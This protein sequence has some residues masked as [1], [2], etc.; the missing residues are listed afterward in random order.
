MNIEASQVRQEGNSLIFRTVPVVGILAL[1]SFTDDSASS[2]MAAAFVKK[3]RYTTNGVTYSN[4]FDLTAPNMLQIQ[5]DPEGIFVAEI[6]YFK[7]E[8]AGANYLT[9]TEA[10]FG[11]NQATV[12]ES[13]NFYFNNSLFKKYFNSTDPDVLN[14]YINVLEKLYEKGLVANFIERKDI[15]GSVEDF[16]SFFG[17]VARFFAFYVKLARV[18]GS[19]YTNQMLIEEFL[20]ERGLMVSPED[21]LQ[22]LQ[23]M[24]ETY[25]NQM[26]QRGT[27]N[28]LNKKADGSDVDG[29]LLRLI[30]FKSID[31]FLFCLYKKENFGWNVHNSSP[32]YKGL[33]VNQNLNKI[34]WSKGYV[35]AI[36]ADNFLTGGATINTGSNTIEVNS[37]GGGIQVLLADAVQID[38]SIDYEFSFKIKLSASHT[39]TFNLAGYNS[40]NVLVTNTSRASGNATNNFFLNAKM[41]RTDKYIE[42]RC[43]LYNKNRGLFAGDTTNIR[44]GRNILANQNL[45]K[46]VFSILTNGVASMKDFLIT[47]MRTVYSRGFLQV[48]NFISSWVKNRNSDF[49]LSELRSF[50]ATY[51]IPYDSHI[52]LT[53]I[54]DNLYTD[55]Q[56]DT[57][58]TYWVGAGEYCRKVT[59]IGE[60]PSC[61][62]Q[63]T[64]WVPDED[65]AICEQG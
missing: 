24:M 42:V 26:G 11:A 21:T 46:V 41:S 29:E 9:V 62:I 37:S 55:P 52:E 12:D 58:T 35:S 56:T 4:W 36:G 47:P 22:D 2:D 6:S 3:F 51:L 25:Y 1:T 23:Y 33:S 15:N 65:T 57:D 63:S 13:L 39:F 48:N 8:P 16:L 50:I 44:Q 17:T 19:F 34:P 40:S 30:H 27:R 61:E 18:F 32:L 20:T 5:V 14:W 45:N 43:F 28:I 10:H 59:W 31:E 38:P 53:N 64:V 7:N 60:D 54:G 49:S